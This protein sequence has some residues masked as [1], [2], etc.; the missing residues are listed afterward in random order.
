MGCRRHRRTPTA[1][2]SRRLDAEAAGTFVARRA[3]VGAFPGLLVFR[4]TVFLDVAVREQIS[5]AVLAA[6]VYGLVNPRYAFARLRVDLKGWVVHAAYDVKSIAFRTVIMDDLIGI[7]RHP[8]F[9]LVSS[10]R[11][12][13]LY[14]ER[15]DPAKAFHCQNMSS[16]LSLLVL[17]AAPGEE[18]APKPGEGKI[19]DESHPRLGAAHFLSGAEGIGR[20][21]LKHRLEVRA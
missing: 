6:Y 20:M 7:H 14:Q 1:H 9:T 5:R 12:R 10:Q 18:T 15:Y 16:M 17:P 19:M 8:G 3:F 13:A 21:G 2:Q 11:S 4:E